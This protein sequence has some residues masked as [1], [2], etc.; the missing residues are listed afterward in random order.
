M[1]NQKAV[2]AHLTSKQ[3]LPFSFAERLSHVERWDAIQLSARLIVVVNTWWPGADQFYMQNNTPYIEW[4]RNTAEE[5]QKAVSASLQRKQILP[6]GFAR[7]HRSITT[8][9]GWS[10]VQQ[11]NMA[12]S[13]FDLSIHLPGRPTHIMMGPVAWTSTLTL[14]IQTFMIFVIVTYIISRSSHWYWKR[15]VDQIT[16]IGNEM[17]VQT[18]RFANVLYQMKQYQEYIINTY[19]WQHA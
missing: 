11:L 18:S 17:C 6:S 13:T 7:R 10:D 2:S 8:A 16:D 19:S 4:C 5:N 9:S 12:V 15:N 14:L 3:I 1:L